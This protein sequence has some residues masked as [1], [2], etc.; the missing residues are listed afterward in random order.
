[1]HLEMSDECITHLKHQCLLFFPGVGDVRTYIFVQTK[2]SWR[3]ARSYCWNLSS[4]L[5]T[6]HSAEENKAVRNI[7]TS[8]KLWIGLFKDPWTWSGGS[9][10]SFRFWDTNEPRYGSN[11][12]CV[13]ADL[14]NNGTWSSQNCNNGNSVICGTGMFFFFFVIFEESCYLNSVKV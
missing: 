6:I 4:D 7:S 11:G 8:E 3:D 10:S 12:N 1:M 5:V 14:G 9:N 2:K 13:T